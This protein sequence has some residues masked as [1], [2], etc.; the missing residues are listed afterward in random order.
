[1]GVVA[2]CLA[3][4]LAVVLILR[5]RAWRRTHATLRAR[6]AERSEQA[7]E[8]ERRANVTQVVSGLA[9]ELK[10]LNLMFST[11]DLVKVMGPGSA[12]FVQMSNDIGTLEPGKLAD[13]V[14]FPANPL[15]G[16]WNMLNATMVIKGGEVVV[17][18]RANKPLDTARGR[19]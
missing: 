9:Q 2:S 19:R 7:R 18:K 12:A 3:A 10:T 17:D 6:M 8:D 4:A 13:I 5:E 11:K 1:M 14:V 15:D 16:Y